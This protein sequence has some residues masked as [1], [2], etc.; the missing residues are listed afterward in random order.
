MPEVIVKA[1]VC[2]HLQDVLYLGIDIPHKLH[3]V[4][5]ALLITSKQLSKLIQYPLPV[6]IS[7]H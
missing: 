6:Q 5:D 3:P 4:I 1:I 7:I 2:C